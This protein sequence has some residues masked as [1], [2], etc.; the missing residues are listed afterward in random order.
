MSSV[1]ALVILAAVFVT[2]FISGIFGMAGGLILM[3]VLVAVLPVSA[4]MIVHGSVQM[5]SNGYRAFLLRQHIDWRII[6]RYAAGSVAAFGVLLLILWR[7]E[8]RIVYLFLGLSSLLVWVPPA[9]VDLDARKPWRAEL[10]GASVQ[11]LNTLSGIGGTLLDLFFVR[12]GMNRLEIVATKGATQVLAHLVKVIFWTLPMLSANGATGLPPAWVFLVAI[13]LSMAGTTLGG[14]V[15]KRMTDT[16]FRTWTLWIVTAMGVY[17]LG[18]AV[19][20]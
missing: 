9:W 17:F 16:N 10:A 6:A 8:T 18:R 5:V 15:L 13:P 12:T 3:A 19:V 2:A 11:T 20:G 14:E 7:P 4:A 1:S